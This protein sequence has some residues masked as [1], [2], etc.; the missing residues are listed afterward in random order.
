MKA[1]ESINIPLLRFDKKRLIIICILAISFSIAFMLRALPIEYGFYLNEFDPYFDYRATQYLVENGFDAYFNWHDNMSW[2]PEGR[3]ISKTSQTGLHITAAVLYKIF[4]FG[5]PLYDFVVWFPVI[6]GSLLTIVVFGLVRVIAGNIAGVFASIFTSLSPSIIQRGNLGWFKSEPLGLFYGVLAIYLLLSALKHKDLKFAIIKAAV[7]GLLLGFGMTA[8]G[9]VQYFALL[10]SLFF[11]TLPFFSKER[12]IIYILPIFTILTVITAASFP[13]PGGVFLFSLPS[14]GLIGSTIFAIAANFVSKDPLKEVRNKF[15]LLAIFVG[16]ASSILIVGVYAP[17]SFRYISVVNPFSK[18]DIPLVE[19]VA[20][21]FTPTIVDYT[22]DYS[23]L[24]LLAGYGAFISFRKRTPMHIFALVLGL[25]GIYISSSFARLM[26]F[27]SLSIIVLAAIAFVEI[28][29]VIFEKGYRVRSIFDP[30]DSR[31]IYSSLMITMLSVPLFYPPNGNWVAMADIPPTISNGAT[32]L[33]VETRDWID[34]LEWIKNNT[35]KD[36]VIASWWDY[37]YWITVLG[38]RSTLAD[39]ATIN[40]TRIERIAAALTS[41][42]EEGIKILKDELK[43]DYLL[44]YMVAQRIDQNFLSLGGGGD[45][46]KKHWFMRIA[47]V[48][49]SRYIQNDGFT[50]TAEF[51]F[52]LLGKTFPVIPVGYASINENGTVSV[53]PQFTRGS[54]AIYMEQVKYDE[55]GAL[56]LVYSSPSFNDKSSNIVFG[57]L[58]YKIK[59]V[60]EKEKVDYDARVK[61]ISSRLSSGEYAILNLSVDGRDEGA[62]VIELMPD[63]APKTVN[64]FKKLIDTGFYDGIKIHRVVKDF[65]I[66]GGDP[67]TKDKSKDTWGLGGPGYTIEAE[68]SNMTHSR[69]VVAMAHPGDPNLAGSQFYIVVKDAP[70]LDGE[71]TIFGQVIEGMEIV[72]RINNLPTDER[73]IPLLDVTIEKAYTI[74]K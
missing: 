7:G 14:L 45:E 31:L 38:E 9:G 21:H 53:Q 28:T 13:R 71:Y 27:S 26:V 19:S 60:V 44:V 72:D 42:E 57:V 18:S 47:G 51:W 73:S 65:V 67:N 16:I 64:N 12:S 5:M 37:G 41:E 48:N 68:I 34:A 15:I 69:G 8:W 1:T 74:S 54:T 4:G 3:D 22:Q 17:S 36:A 52:T 50:P 70:H 2:Y 10:L 59:G 39:N 33:R 58:I 43:A 32:S 56:E 46:S 66:Q 24:L 35:E 40:S 20:E 23:T 62:V 49:E 11:V 25:T 29:R 6:F 55:N 30:R 63:I 61:E